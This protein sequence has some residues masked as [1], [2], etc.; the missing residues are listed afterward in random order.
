MP[1]VHHDSC[2][3]GTSPLPWWLPP[4]S[5]MPHS[6]I[7]TEIP[8]SP[9]APMATCLPNLYFPSPTPESGD[10]M[11]GHMGA[12]GQSSY[13][14]AAPGWPHDYP[15]FGGP[16][17]SLERSVGMVG[18][19]SNVLI[20][21]L[22]FLCHQLS[23]VVPSAFLGQLV[24]SPVQASSPRDQLNFSPTATLSPQLRTHSGAPHCLTVQ[25]AIVG[26]LAGLSCLP[27]NPPRGR[28]A[29]P[30][31]LSLAM[32]SGPQVRTQL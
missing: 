30:A 27:L 10:S 18:F 22:A 25:A 8:P 3:L 31:P 28:E 16:G 11:P 1:P 5:D 20:R 32:L 23:T 15:F 14:L 13:G 7:L 24:C 12:A 17:L 4:L 21:L 9:A 19:I 2:F 29:R 6:N 26:S